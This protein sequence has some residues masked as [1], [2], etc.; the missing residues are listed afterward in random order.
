M[1]LLNFSSKGKLTAQ[2]PL[3]PHVGLGSLHDDGTPLPPGLH[4][5]N[6]NTVFGLR[7]IGVDPEHIVEVPHLH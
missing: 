2:I 3:V 4:A 7:H 5:Q 1:N 6:A